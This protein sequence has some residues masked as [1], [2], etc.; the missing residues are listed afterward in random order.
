M[1]VDA[2]SGEGYV[3]LSGTSMATP[4]AAGVAAL[5]YQANPE[6]SPFDIR[7]IMQETATYRECYYMSD[8][9]GI[10]G[11]PADGTA[12]LVGSEMCIRDRP[13]VNRMD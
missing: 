5:M 13:W 10:K 11:C 9:D 6:L 1:S 8:P 7:N 4:G 2:N 12:C 3:G